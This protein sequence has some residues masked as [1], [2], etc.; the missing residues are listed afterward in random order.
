MDLSIRNV[1]IPCGEICGDGAEAGCDG[2]GSPGK[3]HGKIPDYVYLSGLPHLYWL[4]EKEGGETILLH[5]KN[6][7][8]HDKK[9]LLMPKM[10]GHLNDGPEV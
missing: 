10:P 4:H 5:R 9:C 8:H 6:V 3:D 1:V 2:A 7:M